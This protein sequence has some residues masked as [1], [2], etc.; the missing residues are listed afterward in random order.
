MSFI[1]HKGHEGLEASDGIESDPLNAALKVRERARP[2]LRDL[3]H[4]FHF[5]QR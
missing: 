2:S 5:P 3:N 4:F 1:N